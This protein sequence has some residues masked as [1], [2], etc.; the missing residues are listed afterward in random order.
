MSPQ[1]FGF[2]LTPERLVP[3]FPFGNLDLTYGK[4]VLD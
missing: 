4:Y 1:E 3:G 2:G